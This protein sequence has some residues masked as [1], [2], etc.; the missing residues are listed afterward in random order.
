MAKLHAKVHAIH[1][2][3]EYVRTVLGYYLPLPLRGTLPTATVV[4]ILVP[5]IMANE[6]FPRSG[7]FKTQHLKSSLP[8]LLPLLLA[9]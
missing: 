6:R 2:L 1:I 3:L 9:S 8:N 7:K 5:G 4:D